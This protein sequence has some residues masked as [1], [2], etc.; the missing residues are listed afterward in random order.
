MLLQL[1][2]QRK[3]SS[4]TTECIQKLNSALQAELRRKK[5]KLGTTEHLLEVRMKVEELKA[6][7]EVELYQLKEHNLKMTLESQKMEIRVDELQILLLTL[8]E[9][10]NLFQI[11]QEN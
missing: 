2:E 1:R 4:S 6:C 10:K 5:Q 11:S 8:K 9:Q 3:R 7:W